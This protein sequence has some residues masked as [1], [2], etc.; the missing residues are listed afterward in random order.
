MLGRLLLR[1]YSGY[2]LSALFVL[3]SIVTVLFSSILPTTSQQSVNTVEIAA[4]LSLTGDSYTFGRG[5][6]EGIQLAIEEANASGI[7]PRITLTPY[8]DKSSDDEAKEVANKIVASQ[9]ALVLGPAIS[10]ISLAEGPIFAKAGIASLTTTATADS[11]TQNPTTFRVIFKNSDQGELLATY[12]YQVLGKRQASVLVVD[13]KYGQSLQEGFK[14]TAEQLG[15]DAQYYVFKAESNAEQMARQIA[16]TKS[17]SPIVFLTLDA[18]GARILTALR[19]LG[20]NGPFLG[21]DPFGDESFSQRLVDQPEEKKQPGYFTNGL[22]GLS[23][24][25]LDSANADILTFAERF[26]ERFHHDPVWFSVAGYDAARLAIETLRAVTAELGTGADLKTKR[27][28]VLNYLRSLDSPA[29]ALPG[30]LNPFWFDSTR[31]RQQ[32]IRVGQFFNNRFESAPL[33][34]VPVT[35]PDTTELAS[36]AVFKLGSDHYARLQRVVYTGVFLNEISRVDLANSSFNADFYLWLRFAKDANPGSADPTDLIFPTAVK[37]NFNRTQPAEQREVGGSTQYRLWRV[38]GEFRNDYDLRLFPFDRQALSLSLFNARAA[39]ERVVYVLDKRSTFGVS[40]GS[41][42]PSGQAMATRSATNRSDDWLAIASPVAFRNLT[43]WVPLSARSRRENLVT[44]SSLGDPTRIGVESQRELSG[45][46]VTVNLQRRTFA[47]L[48][49]SLLP[50]ILMTLIMYAS[51]YFPIALVKEKVTVAVTSAL[52]GAVLLTSINNQLGGIGYTIAVE[53]IFYV[54]FCLSLLCIVAV[55][56][57]ERL[58]A[59]HRKE[60]AALVDRWTRI[61]FLVAVAITLIAT[62]VLYFQDKSTPA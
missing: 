28:A 8:D 26:R 46:L 35:T 27:T 58:R 24:M 20:V 18:E 29:K 9:A 45:F 7:E 54:F 16:D 19:R 49:K 22:Y 59:A 57:A 6:L 12:L 39:M 47:T 23:P 30:L 62:L 11:I 5:S 52:S 15:I 56:G 32:A 2:F 17:Q 48:T 14:R 13:S 10:T 61:T 50:L 55:L 25:I 4:A 21:A 31:G 42:P 3:S 37:N 34:I 51:L 53:Y 43:Q 38:Q 41:T 33:Q 36:G 1:R 44:A 60:A 40:K